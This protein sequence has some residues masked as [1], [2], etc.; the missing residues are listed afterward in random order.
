MER[1][2]L[3]VADL[4]G[5]CAVCGLIVWFAGSAMEAP[6]QRQTAYEAGKNDQYLKQLETENTYLRGKTDG[7]QYPR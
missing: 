7:L 1:E 4:V 5:A 3:K 6:K 2:G